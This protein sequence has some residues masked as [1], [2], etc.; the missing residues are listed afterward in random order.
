MESLQQQEDYTLLSLENEN[1]KHLTLKLELQI[2]WCGGKNPFKI[3]ETEV[4]FSVLHYKLWAQSMPCKKILLMKCLLHSKVYYSFAY[5]ILQCPHL[6]AFIQFIFTE[7]LQCVNH[8]PQHW[9]LE[10]T[11]HFGKTHKQKITS[12]ISIRREKF[13]VLWD[14]MMWVPGQMTGQGKPKGWAEASQAK[15][16]GR[17]GAE[18]STEKGKRESVKVM[19]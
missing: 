2:R 7:R 18:L 10:P 12:A 17:G 5:L 9:A 8:N 4:S 13:R 19:Q 16:S 6:N 14:H 3:R 1:N 15:E 11:I